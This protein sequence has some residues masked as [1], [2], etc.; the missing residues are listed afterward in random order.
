MGTVVPCLPFCHFRKRLSIGERRLLAAQIVRTRPAGIERNAAATF[1]DN[2][3][4][5]LR[6]LSSCPRTNPRNPSPPA[7]PG[8]GTGSRSAPSSPSAWP[9]W[10]RS[11]SGGRSGR[12]APVARGAGS[13][14]TYSAPGEPGWAD[15]RQP[16]HSPSPRM[17][18]SPP[19]AERKKRTSCEPKK[20]SPELEMCKRISPPNGSQSTQLS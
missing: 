13:T 8:S 4:G 20:S 15:W 14:Q 16:G 1:T 7:A 6:T 19:D 2:T 12:G 18:S 3:A 10:R 9:S 5:L 11:S 17:N